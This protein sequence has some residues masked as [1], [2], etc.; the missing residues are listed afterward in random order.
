MHLSLED[1]L[2]LYFEQQRK[3]T[4]E[5]WG[6]TLRF[7]KGEF[8]KI[9]APSGSGKTSLMHFLYGLRK[10]Y[11]GTIRYGD[12]KAKELTATQLSTYRSDKLSIVCRTCGCFP[13]RP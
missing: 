10:E 2:P 7:D 5:V 11:S 1:I 8:I 4:S 6:K 9:V 3:E 13:T 12:A